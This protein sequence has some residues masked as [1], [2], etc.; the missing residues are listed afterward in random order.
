MLVRIWSKGNT[1]QPL[2][3]SI[4]HFLGKLGIG[5]PQEP[6]ISLLGIYLKDVLPSHKGTCSTMYV[7]VLSFIIKVSKWMSL[8]CFGFWLL[9]LMV[10]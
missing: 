4:W 9:S 3:K 8:P 2:W 10:V 5:L 7:D 6:A 1:P